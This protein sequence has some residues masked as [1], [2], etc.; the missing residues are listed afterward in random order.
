MRFVCGDLPI[1]VE[2]R[3]AK[4]GYDAVVNGEPLSFSLGPVKDGCCDVRLSGA[5]SVLHFARDGR[6]LHLFWEGVVYRLDEQREGARAPQRHD[7]GALEAPMPGRVS[8]VKVAVGQRVSKGQE[9]VVVEAMKME[10]A[11]RAPWAGV[12][13]ALYA[14]PGDM[15]APGRPLVEVADEPEGA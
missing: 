14:G 11:L 7:T 15:V 2:L 12:V 13:R 3:D 6:T 8:A 5:P 10:N 1:D 4:G 9:L